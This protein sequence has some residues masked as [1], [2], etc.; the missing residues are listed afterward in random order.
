MVFSAGRS[1]ALKTASIWPDGLLQNFTP[2]AKRPRRSR[3]GSRKSRLS[4]PYGAISEPWSF[5]TLMNP[6]RS[7]L[8]Q[9]FSSYKEQHACKYS[10][11]TTTS[12]RLFE[13]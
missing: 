13:S 8:L 5:A 4:T 11:E 1:Y 7:S 12:S 10:S 2:A 6:A 3:P 9:L